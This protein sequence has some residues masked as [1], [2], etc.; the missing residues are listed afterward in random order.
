[1]TERATLID[2]IRRNGAAPD[3]LNRFLR[4]QQSEAA[5]AAREADQP[6]MW[7][8][9][10]LARA[11]EAHDEGT[12]NHTQRVNEYSHLLARLA[13]LPERFL[14]EIRYA[15]QL[16]DVGKLAISAPMLRKQSLLDPDERAAMNSHP[17]YGYQILTGVPRLEMAAE[18]ALAH[19]EKWD[20]SGYPH[21][22]AGEALPLSA[23]IVALADVYDALRSERPY[24]RAYGHEEA[25]ETLLNGDERIHPAGHFD[26]GLLDLFRRHDAG[27][28]AIW[29]EFH[30]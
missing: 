10:L 29:R 20:G 21:G 13:G 11:A 14:A 17:E 16:H 28:A 5:E 1:M 2:S 8:I 9:A 27:F 26:P 15:A 18:I 25:A 22:L 7:A 24:K 4:Q 23:R 30:D 6:F 19:H 3:Q 12:G